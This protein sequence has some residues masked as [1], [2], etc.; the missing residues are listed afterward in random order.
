MNGEPS[1]QLLE[2]YRAARAEDGDLEYATAELHYT[3]FESCE[4]FREVIVRHGLQLVAECPDEH[5]QWLWAAPDGLKLR[6]AKAPFEGDDGY[7]S[8]TYIRGPAGGA[9]RLFEDVAETAEYIKGEFQPLH[10]DEGEEIVSLWDIRE[11]D[12]EVGGEQ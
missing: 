12:V 7:L 11:S 8:Y 4:A 10:T 2:R 1:P 9:E 5:Y 3:C 6:T